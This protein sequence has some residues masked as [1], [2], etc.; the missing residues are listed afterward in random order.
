MVEYT[1]K[2]LGRIVD[3]I[4]NAGIAENTLL[5]FYSDNGTNQKIETQTKWG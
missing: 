1:D 4:D 2:I 3:A 5:I